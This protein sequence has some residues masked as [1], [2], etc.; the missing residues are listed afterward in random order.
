MFFHSL[1]ENTPDEK[2]KGK[3]EQSLSI[4]CIVTFFFALRHIFLQQVCR[5]KRDRRNRLVDN[6]FVCSLQK[7]TFSLMYIRQLKF[8][9]ILS[10]GPVI[11][12]NEFFQ[13]KY[14]NK[15]F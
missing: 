4:W 5:F 14:F 12:E 1:E 13:L 7:E 6:I 2:K 15:T 3:V 10:T 8:L 11:V 9:L